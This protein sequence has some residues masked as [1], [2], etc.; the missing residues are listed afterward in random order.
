MAL[1]LFPAS[2]LVYAQVLG[3]IPFDS[4]CASTFYFSYSLPVFE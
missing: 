2:F 1:P 3:S 4:P